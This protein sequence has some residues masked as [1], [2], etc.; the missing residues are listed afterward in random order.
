M[1]Q[2]VTS[3]WPPASNGSCNVLCISHACQLTAPQ[4]Y[5]GCFVNDARS[6][7][8][9]FETSS[10]TSLQP[11]T[12]GLTVRNEN[13]PYLYFLDIS[14]GTRNFGLATKEKVSLLI[15]IA[16]HKRTCKATGSQALVHTAKA[17]T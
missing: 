11:V 10:A 17:V 14:R 16:T 13:D 5:V 9:V 7:W 8:K 12:V 3:A 15:F 1:M 4:M 6:G 2:Q